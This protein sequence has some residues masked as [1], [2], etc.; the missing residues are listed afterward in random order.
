MHIVLFGSTGGTGSEVIKQ[1]LSRGH[2]IT[3][4]ARTPEQITISNPL[5]TTVPGDVLD[6]P[7]LNK[8]VV[9]ADAAISVLGV[10]L[11]Q[12]PG[13]VRST[14]TRNI[15]AALTLAKVRRFV[16]VSTIGIGD[17]V[18]QM[19]WMMRMI[20]PRIIGAERLR[21]AALQE[22]IIAE[23]HLDW[24]VLRPTRL[25]DDAATG[26]YQVGNHI[27]TGMSAKLARADLAKALLDQIEQSAFLRQTPIVT[28]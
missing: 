26:T 3:A 21:E 2:Q 20:W 5:L 12:A 11:G 23:S 28:A 10:R 7:T 1:A 22:Q 15:V 17:S 6:M 8:V 13:V 19:S 16:S 25:T 14:G 4:L 18:N 27:Q 24:T 9:G